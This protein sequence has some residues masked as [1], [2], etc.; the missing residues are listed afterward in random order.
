MFISVSRS[1]NIHSSGVMAP[2]SSAKVVTF[3]RW[4]MIRV[5]SSKSVRIQSARSGT[6]VPSSFST[7]STK[8]CSC[9]IG[10]T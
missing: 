6:S 3:R 10:E 8:A 2:Q 1:S 4:F 7:A 9:I 5:S